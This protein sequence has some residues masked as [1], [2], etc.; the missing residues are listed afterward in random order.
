MMSFFYFAISVQKSYINRSYQRSP[1]TTLQ[2][3]I[4]FCQWPVV[5]YTLCYRVTLWS[6]WYNHWSVRYKAG[7]HTHLFI[8][9]FIQLIISA[10]NSHPVACVN[11]R[12][13]CCNLHPASHCDFVR[14]ATYL[15]SRSYF[16]TKLQKVAR[17]WPMR[18]LQ[19]I[20]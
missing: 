8:C 13:T 11:G 18:T 7:L 6:F 14:P 17:F 9:N 16:A 19:D 1:I 15:R 5:T 3:N 20:M 12:A 4:K 2:F 10:N